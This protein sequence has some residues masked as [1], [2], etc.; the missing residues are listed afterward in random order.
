MATLREPV[1]QVNDSSVRT[2]FS[3]A[4]AWAFLSEWPLMSVALF[5]GSAVVSVMSYMDSWFPELFIRNMGWTPARVGHVNGLASLIAGPL[6]MLSAGYLS[7]RL[8]DRGMTDACLRL[9][10]VAALGM[11]LVGVVMP[12][13]PN[14]NVMAALHFPFKFFGGFTPV[15]IT[16]AIQMISP[17]RL[18][19]QL[20]AV[21]MLTVGIVGVTLGPVLP[22]LLSDYVLRDERMLYLSLV[23]TAAVVA[24][25]A[26]VLLAV[27]LRQFRERVAELADI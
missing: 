25:P 13:M 3:F 14:G 4:R 12:L 2:G 17:D 18:R 16:S 1:S 6:G 21:F 27:G 20:G 9:T 22:A 24:P 23:L 26:I 15:L 5:L 11:R 7:S 8:L 10:M 19:G